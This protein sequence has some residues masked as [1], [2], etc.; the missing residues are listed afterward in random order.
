MSDQVK[1]FRYFTLYRPPMPG[2]IPSGAVE[3]VEFE[4]PHFVEDVRHNAWG[5]A[6]YNR[7]LTEGE[8]SDYELAPDPSNL[9]DGPQEGSSRTY[10]VAMKER[11]DDEMSIWA[12]PFTSREKAEAFVAKVKQRLAQYGM[13]NEWQIDID[14][15]EMNDEQYLV[16]IDARYEDY[17]KEE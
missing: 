17:E 5:F 13:E 7:P 12:S 6:V 3:A 16:W 14:S 11:S 2:A 9:S 15:G 10:I 1:R 4:Y 8:I